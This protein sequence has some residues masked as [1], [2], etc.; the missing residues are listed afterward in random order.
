MTIRNPVEWVYDSFRPSNFRLE[1]LHRSRAELDDPA[2]AIRRIGFS[3]LGDSLRKGIS[4]FGARRTDV[5][6]IGIIYPLAG[7]LIARLVLNNDLLPLVFP[8][9]SGFALIGPFAAAGL[10]EMSRRRELGYD[11]SWADAF[12]VVGRPAFGSFVV[13][14]L[15]MTVLYFLWLAVAMGIYGIIMGF[16][17]PASVAAFLNEILTTPN[18]MALIVI[19]CGVGLLFALVAFAMS[20]VSFPL[21]LDRKVTLSTAVTTSVRAV[22][23]NPVPML[24][25][26]AIVA[27]ALVIGSLPLLLGLIVVMPVLGHATWHL[28]R[29]VL[30]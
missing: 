10:Y 28:Y 13:L 26:G 22:L 29:K 3:D 21:L 14:A 27:G 30:D 6:F 18:G 8:V 16:T 5:L 11:V 9:I 17:A 15:L 7:L 4:D 23:A 12:E 2:P 24:A 25:W 20:V 1:G 19:G